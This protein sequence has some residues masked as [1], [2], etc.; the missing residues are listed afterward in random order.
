MLR[1]TC[2]RGAWILV[3]VVNRRRHRDDGLVAGG[4]H[5]RPMDERC[6]FGASGPVGAPTP[7][8]LGPLSRPPDQL[9]VWKFG[10]AA[11]SF[12]LGGTH[13]SRPVRK[14]LVPATSH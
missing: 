7:T 12:A 4:H 6:R 14:V 1:C 13:L 9:P 10:F 2:T 5:R 8:R 3:P 11:C